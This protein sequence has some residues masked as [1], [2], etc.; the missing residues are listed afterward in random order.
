VLAG[1]VGWV[2]D[3]HL[4]LVFELTL[5]IMVFQPV[6][7]LIHGF[8]GFGCHGTHFE[9]LCGDIVGGNWGWIGLIVPQFLESGA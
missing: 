1:V 4:P 8:Q 9:A 2:E 5:G 3:A 6:K 7:T